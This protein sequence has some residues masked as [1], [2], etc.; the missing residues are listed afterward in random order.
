MSWMRPEFLVSLL[1]NGKVKTLYSTE[2][3][4]K[5]E[6]VDADMVMSYGIASLLNK[7]N[8]QR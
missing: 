3:N 4:I 6:I 8:Y 2:S 7:L 1:F 5:N